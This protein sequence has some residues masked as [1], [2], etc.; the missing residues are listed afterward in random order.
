MKKLAVAY[1]RVSTKKQADQRQEYSVKEH[2]GKEDFEIV[3]V[4]RETISGAKKNKPE[5]A[6]A[7]QYIEDNNIKYLVA[8]ELTRLGRTNEVISIIDSLTEKGVCVCLQKENIKTLNEDFTENQNSSLIIN[9]LTGMAK[10]ELTTT[11]YRT[12]DGRKN[13]VLNHHHYG[14]G[15]RGV[16]GYDIIKKKLVINKDEAAVVRD[17]FNKFIEGWG[18]IKIANYLNEKEIPTKL[19]SLGKKIRLPNSDEYFEGNRTVWTRSSVKNITENQLYIGIRKFD[20]IT[21]EQPELR[22]ISDDIFDVVQKKKTE[23]KQVN[24][25]LNFKKRY[26]YL[27]DNK[28]IRC[29]E[30]NRHFTGISSKNMYTCTQNKYGRYCENENLNMEKFDQL[31]KDFITTNYRNLVFDTESLKKKVHSIDTEKRQAE[32]QLQTLQGKREKYIEMYADGTLTKE[33]MQK[34]IRACDDDIETYEANVIRLS[35]DLTTY[36]LQLL[37][38]TAAQLS[39]DKNHE[40]ENSAVDSAVIHRLIK[41]IKVGKRTDGK[42][43]IT[44][45]MVNDELHFL[46]F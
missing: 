16:Y 39:L 5:L 22:I 26:S 2:F 40:A 46:G 12:K 25:E 35:D 6:K 23:H 32:K 45:R 18:Y 15:S 29:G 14:G 1:Y 13:A 41:E 21:F 37:E 38:N 11:R 8:S 7:L 20:G 33:A 34:K 19:A 30:C 28:I 43:Q 36:R 24:S 31:I 42:R 17:I 10:N 44:V 27:L 9:F 3:Q 4:F